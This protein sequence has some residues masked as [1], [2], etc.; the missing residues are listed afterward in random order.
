MCWQNLHEILI[1]LHEISVSSCCR[2]A[3]A[4]SR[5]VVNLGIRLVVAGRGSLVWYDVGTDHVK[6]LKTREL[7]YVETPKMRFSAK[8]ARV[9]FA[10]N[11]AVDDSTRGRGS[12]APQTI[13]RGRRL[14]SSRFQQCVVTAF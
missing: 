2:G 12:S 3:A 5:R 10:F 14:Q 13:K 11:R 9:F 7:V 8:F 1:F 6:F 4:G